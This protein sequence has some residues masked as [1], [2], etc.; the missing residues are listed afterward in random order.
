MLTDKEFHTAAE[1]Y[2]DM[3]YRLAL[4]TL[5][6][7]A[8]AEDAAQNVMLRLC[9]S[10]EKL[11]GEDHLRYW[12]VRVTLNECK[13]LRSNPWL[14]NPARSRCFPLRSVASSFWM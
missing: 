2:L 14:W 4:N 6:H 12:L 13:R 3:V 5:R 1:R 9:Q 8:D 7:P 10:R 11:E